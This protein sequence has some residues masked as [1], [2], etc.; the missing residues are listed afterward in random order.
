MHYINKHRN[1]HI[2]KKPS[3]IE[4]FSNKYYTWI[5]YIDNVHSN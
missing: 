5:N 4:H 2:Y 3:N 1:I